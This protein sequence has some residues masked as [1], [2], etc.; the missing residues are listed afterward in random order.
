MDEQNFNCR[1]LRTRDLNNNAKLFPSSFFLLEPRNLKPQKKSHRISTHISSSLHLFR[2]SKQPLFERP[3]FWHTSFHDNSRGKQ[4]RCNFFF[5]L[6]RFS[7][8]AR[9]LSESFAVT[10]S[11]WPL[12]SRSWRSRYCDCTKKKRK[13]EKKKELSRHIPNDPDGSD[14]EI[15]TACQCQRCLAAGSQCQWR[16]DACKGQPVNYV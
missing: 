8:I 1:Y 10:P 9:R 11:L 15:A 13:K 7:L 5:S 16:N 4:K 12:F 2:R 3:P 6:P 14:F